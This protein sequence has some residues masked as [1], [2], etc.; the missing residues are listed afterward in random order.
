MIPTLHMASQMLQEPCSPRSC[1]KSWRARV[2]ESSVLILVVWKYL[3]VS[4]LNK[5]VYLLAAA[6]QSGLQR[7]FTEDFQAQVGEM[8]KAGCKIILE[9]MLA[10]TN[11]WQTWLIW[12]GRNSISLHGLVDPRELQ[13][14]SLAWL[15]LQL[16]ASY[17]AAMK[18]KLESANIRFTDFNGSYISQ[19]AI[20]DDD[21]HTHILDEDNWTRLWEISERLVGVKY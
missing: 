12:M 7:H 3:L 18:E 20:A 15:T 6:V 17:I 2:S 4:L 5:T 19:N 9:I 21:L 13:T 10:F 16:Q 14:S 8:M 1:R 11:Y